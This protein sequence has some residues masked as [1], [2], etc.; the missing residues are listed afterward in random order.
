MVSPFKKL[1]KGVEL[2]VIYRYSRQRLF[3]FALMFF[4][5]SSIAFGVVTAPQATPLLRLDFVNPENWDSTF[6]LEQGYL[7]MAYE[8]VETSLKQKVVDDT[9]IEWQKTQDVLW[10]VPTDFKLDLRETVTQ[11]VANLR[12]QKYQI[13]VVIDDTTQ[14]AYLQ[15]EQVLP[16][17]KTAVIVHEVEINSATPLH[18]GQARSLQEGGDGLGS[19]WLSI[20]SEDI[21]PKLAIVIDDWGYRSRAAEPLLS[22]P[23]PLTMAVLPYLA[24]SQELA[25]RAASLG[26]EVI[27]HQPMQPLNVYLDMGPGGIYVDMSGDEIRSRLLSNLQ[28]LP[29]V[30]GMNNHM[31]SKATT[32]PHTM[33]VVLATLKELE[34]FFLDSRTSPLTITQTIAEMIELPY[35]INDFFL[36]NVN[37]TE[38]IKDQ[39][40]LA[41][42]MA[43]RRGQAIV[44]GHVRVHTATALWEMIPEI[45][46]SGVQLVP[47]SSVLTHPELVTT[48]YTEQSE[49]GEY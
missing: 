28:H 19:E 9:L 1:R 15:V 43:K 38:A 8:Q 20:A 27:L 2:V 11:L 44:I 39:I 12:E 34:L 33:E 10:I 42:Q 35:A 4:I 45:V 29:M 26:H 21:Q 14:H 3:L 41:I 36:D 25:H 17:L 48:A 23:F 22:Y 31:G 32:D 24:Q 16:S 30:S 18:G 47:V 49:E 46:E 7:L 40:R 37:E 13:D 6:W 5:L